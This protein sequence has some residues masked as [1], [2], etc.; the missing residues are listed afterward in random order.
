MLKAQGIAALPRDI[1][2]LYPEAESLRLQWEGVYT[3]TNL[4]ALRQMRK[5]GRLRKH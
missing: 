1:T 4:I 2:E 5:L 3:L